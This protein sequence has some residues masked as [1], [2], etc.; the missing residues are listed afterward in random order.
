MVWLVVDFINMVGMVLLLSALPHD[1]NEA[2]D[3]DDD[4]GVSRS[5]AADV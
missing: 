5:D 4:D 2:G 1:D 3:D